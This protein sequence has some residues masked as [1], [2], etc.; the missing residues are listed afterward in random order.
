MNFQKDFFSWNEDKSREALIFWGKV[1]LMGEDVS[2]D[3]VSSSEG[4]SSKNSL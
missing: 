4:I 1:S 2:M 3:N